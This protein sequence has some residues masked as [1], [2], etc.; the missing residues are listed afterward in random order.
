MDGASKRIGN[1]VIES[2]WDRDNKVTC[3]REEDQQKI[4]YSE[5]SV[6]SSGSHEQMPRV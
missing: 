5:H 6:S 2:Q 1:Q 3:A 4:V